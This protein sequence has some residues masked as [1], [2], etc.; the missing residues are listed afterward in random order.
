MPA[1]SG[2]SKRVNYVS[3][4]HLEKVGAPDR[5]DSNRLRAILG[6][7]PRTRCARASKT[8]AR[9]IEPVTPAFGVRQF[10]CK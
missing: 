8:L 6:A 3:G 7:A 1:R 9:F 5:I 2:S 4:I 10:I